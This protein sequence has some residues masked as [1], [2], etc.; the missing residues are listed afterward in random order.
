MNFWGFPGDPSEF[1]N[2]LS[3]GFVDF[4]NTEGAFDPLKSEYLLPT[5]IGGMLRQGE[6]TVKVLPTNDTWYG[7]T[8]KENVVSVTERFGE[9]IKAQVSIKKICIQIYNQWPSANPWK[10]Y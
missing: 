1:I 9:M 5:I 4:F 2:V 6:C 10:A 8:Y 3:S 7:M